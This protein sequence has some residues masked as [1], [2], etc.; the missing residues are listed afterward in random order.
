MPAFLWQRLF[1][2]ELRDRYGNGSDVLALLWEPT[3]QRKPGMMEQIQQL[4][5]WDDPDLS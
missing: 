5:Y 1:S 2:L 4:P 3:K